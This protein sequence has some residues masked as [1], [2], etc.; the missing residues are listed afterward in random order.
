MTE[1]EIRAKSLDLAIGTLSLLSSEHI[2]TLITGGEKDGKL[3][4]EIV[5]KHSLVFQEYLRSGKT[6]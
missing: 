1:Q 3:P 4:S 6:P 2:D 5:I